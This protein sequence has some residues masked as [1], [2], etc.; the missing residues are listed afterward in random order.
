MEHVSYMNFNGNKG[1][2]F[3]HFQP[4]ESEN[5]NTLTLNP[6]TMTI[7]VPPRNVIKWQMGFNSAFK[8]LKNI[9]YT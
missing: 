8:G 4:A 1:N 2:G 5:I 6:P 7:V 3:Q 9:D